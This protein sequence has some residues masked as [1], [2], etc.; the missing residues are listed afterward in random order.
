MEERH[1]MCQGFTVDDLKYLRHT[2]RL[3]AIKTIIG[4]VLGIKP[5][6]KGDTE[7]KIVCFA[8]TRGRKLSIRELAA[9]YAE[10]V[11]SPEKQTIGIAHADCPEDAA[12]LK[13]LIEKTLPPREIMTVV[14][15]PVTGSHVGPGTL[16][17]FFDGDAG[18]RGK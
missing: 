6:L 5:L 4:T 18:F 10:H 13:S 12:F 9:Q 7:G 15:E 11:V 1:T 14:Y 2:G 16:A 8:R 3:S 17:L